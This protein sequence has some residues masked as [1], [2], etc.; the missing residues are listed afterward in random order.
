[1]LRA[2]AIDCNIRVEEKVRWANKITLREVVL[3][4]KIVPPAVPMVG[5]KNT[6]LR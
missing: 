6:W 2:H 1:M 4:A 5:S 3:T